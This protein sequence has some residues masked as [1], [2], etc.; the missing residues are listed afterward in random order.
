MQQGDPPHLGYEF[1]LGDEVTLV[2]EIELGNLVYFERTGPSNLALH[3]LSQDLS[4]FFGGFVYRALPGD[5]E[6][7]VRFVLQNRDGEIL[8]DEEG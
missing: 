8:P 3:S 1:R 5:E 7:V 4:P 6:G 2:D